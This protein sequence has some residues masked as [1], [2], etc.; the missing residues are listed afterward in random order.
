MGKT[1]QRLRALTYK[2]TMQLLRDRRT[3][4]LFFLLPLVELFLFGYAVSLTVDHLPTALVDQSRDNRSRDFVQ[5]L[6]NSGYFN[7][8]L[9]LQNEAQV[10]QAMDR[11]DIRAGVVIPPNF[12]AEVDRGQGKALILLDGSDSFSVESGF[13]AASAIA[14]QYSLNLAAQEVP[15]SSSGPGLAAGAESLPVTVFT[16]VLY[17]PDLQDLVFILPGLMALIIQNIIVAHS[18]MAFVREREGGT[19]E[20]LL[21]SPARPVEMIVAKVIPG[22]L[23]VVLDMAVILFLGVFWFGVP[24]NGNLGLFAILSTLFIVSGMGLG[25]VIST[26]AKTQRQAQQFTNLLNLLAM[27]LTG[28]IYPRLTMPL[29]TRVIGDLVPLTYYITIIRGIITKGVGLSSLWEQALA[30]AIYSVV[31]LLLASSVTSR[32]LD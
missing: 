13:R 20:Q 15:A 21:A 17:N 22:V 8:T 18:A 5:A 14:Q 23:V 32:R 6:V 1:L 11:G 4:A 27:L 10:R 19:L 29:W 26:L 16:R 30:L 31:A 24:F 28:F 25:L 3:L 2:E 12:A 9:T 7:I